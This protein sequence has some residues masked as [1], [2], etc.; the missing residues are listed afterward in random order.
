LKNQNFGDNRDLL[1]FDLVSEIFKSGL[2][3]RF[4]YIPML[5]E[6]IVRKEEP[7]VC[8]HEAACGVSNTE[9]VDFLDGC[10]V[11]DKRSISQLGTYLNKSGIN[12]TIYAGDK[13]FTHE[14]R[15]DYFKNI[16]ID[17]LMNSLILIDPDKGLEERVNDSGNLLYS[18]LKDVYDKMSDGSLLMFTQRFPYDLYETYLEMRV[19][20]IKFNLPF[21]QP[22]SLDDLDTIVFFLTKNKSIQDRF[23]DLLRE[24]T[25]KY[26]K[27]EEGE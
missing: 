27:K 17:A 8:R 22:I 5:T 9:L 23:L 24:Y 1:K 7:H 26:A 19:G 11:N 10:I 15:E 21:S 16:K 18:E 3:D 2:V 12:S 6:D 25:K 20:E 14:G 4:T 13:Y